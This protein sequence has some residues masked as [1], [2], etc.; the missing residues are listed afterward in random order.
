VNLA[1]G[2]MVGHTGVFPA[3]IKAVETVDNCVGRMMEAVKKAGGYLVITADHGNIEEKLDKNNQP[4]TA[5]STNPVPL[6]V[7]GPRKVRL[8]A[9]G[10]ALCDIAPTVLKLMGV[11]QPPEM[12]GKPLFDFAS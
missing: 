4:I 1:N 12:T 5:H 3:A 10:G 9:G 7:V 2:D 6:Y 8:L 11:K